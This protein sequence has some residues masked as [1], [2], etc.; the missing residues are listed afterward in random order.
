MIFCSQFE[1]GDWH[2]KISEDILADA[3]CDHI[4]HDS[5]T[6]VV[7]GKD[8]MRKYK[9]LTVY[10]EKCPHAL[11]TR[12]LAPSLWVPIFHYRIGFSHDNNF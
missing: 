10:F 2:K 9:G 8:S 3:I 7:G 6:I 4:V 1:V 5:Y 11:V 12:G